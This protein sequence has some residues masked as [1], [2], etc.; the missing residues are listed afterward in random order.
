MFPDQ[1]SGYSQDEES[2]HEI[3]C[4]LSLFMRFDSLAESIR[5]NEKNNVCYKK[6]ES[7]QLVEPST[8][9]MLTAL[10][11]TSEKFARE[12]VSAA[13]PELPYSANVT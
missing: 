2:L 3:N 1:L 8:V 5:N 6:S 4:S 11:K 9:E 13:G 12:E 10:L 7:I